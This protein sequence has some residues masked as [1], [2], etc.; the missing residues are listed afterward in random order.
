MT[1]LGFVHRFSPGS[2]SS[3]PVL[4]LLHGTGGD[5]ND[6]IPLGQE[7]LP[8]AAILSVRGKVLE[9]GMPRFFRR[10]AEGVFDL[11]DLKLR[12][13]EL[14]GFLDRARVHYGLGDNDIIAVGYSNG[15]NI[16]A[17]LILRFPHHLPAAVLFRAM[18]PFRPDTLP[19]LSR[20]QIFLSGGQRDTIVPVANTRELAEMFETAGARVSLYWHAGGHE[21][22]SGDVEAA[23]SWLTRQRSEPERTRR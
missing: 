16:A 22:T 23:G 21:L 2:E 13:E 7:L 4:L 10:L 9:N 11:E 6:L 1:D 20:V 8:G 14:A 19:D 5:E 3:A 18:V 17:S 15:A 12:T